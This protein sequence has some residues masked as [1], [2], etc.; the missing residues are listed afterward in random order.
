M[1]TKRVEKVNK[2]HEYNKGFVAGWKAAIRYNVEKRD[3]IS[4]LEPIAGPDTSVLF[5][6]PITTSRKK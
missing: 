3:A 5:S 2:S 6:A 1:K 4:P